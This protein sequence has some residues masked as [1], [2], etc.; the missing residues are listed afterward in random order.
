MIYDKYHMTPGENIF[1]AKR[2]LVDYI[3]KSARLEGFGLTFPDTDAIINGGIAQGLSINVLS[4]VTNGL[5][6]WPPTTK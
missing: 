3:Y 2:N 4:M 5:P 1:V 6:C